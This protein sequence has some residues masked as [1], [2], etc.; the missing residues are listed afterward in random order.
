MIITGEYFYSIAALFSFLAY[1]MGNVLWLR[2]LLVGAAIIYIIS[3]IK[4]GI[5]SM[6]GWNSAYLAINLYHVALLILDK[7]TITLPEE[8][9]EIYRLFFSSMSTRE[10][11]KI[12]MINKFCTVK[13]E[14][15]ITDGEIT[16]RL[17]IVIDGKI[18][19]VKSG[20]ILASL[21]SGDLVGEMSFMSKQPA[22][23]SAIASEVV[24]YAFWTHKDLENLRH[25]NCNVYNKFISIIGCDLVRKLNQKNQE[26][27]KLI[28]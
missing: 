10:F 1:L 17:F 19:I 26:L 7:S 18:D 28:D 23:A 16:D 12:I 24:Q 3:G 6:I 20:V 25:K 2:I 22:S 21:S 27:I 8:T 5:T 13:G 15:L 14:K 11:K 9:K 4:L